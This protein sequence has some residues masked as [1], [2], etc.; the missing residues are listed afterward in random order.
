MNQVICIG[1]DSLDPKLLVK[2]EKDLP[3]FTKLRERSP[4]IHSKSVFPVDSIPAWVS[5]YTGLNPAKHGIIHSFDI[6]E[7][8][9][10]N[11]LGIDINAFKGRT[12][13]DRASKNGKK[14]CILLPFLATPPWDVNGLMV[15]ISTDEF[16]LPEEETWVIKKGIQ[17]YPP[18][19]KSKYQIP[20]F[21][22]GTKGR[23]PREKD[24]DK[25]ISVLKK[26]TIEESKLALRLS[27]NVEWD[28]F[29]MMFSW[30][31]IIQHF[32]WRFSDEDDP[33]YPGENPYRNVIKEFYQI[34]DNILGE[35]MDSYPEMTIIVFSDHGHAMRPVKTVNINEILRKKG[36]LISKSGKMNPV[37]YLLEQ[38]KRTSLDVIKKFELD[39]LM[40][41]VSKSKAFSSISKDIYMS[42]AS[43]DFERSKAYLSSF[44]GPKS[45][46]HAGIDINKQNLRDESY[47]EIRT[48]LIGELLKL[49]EPGTG[50]KLVDWACRREDL[51]QGS[52]LDFYPDVVF[53]L[54]E[55]YGAFW[56]IHTPLI[57]TAY[58]HKLASG[59]HHK[60][61]VFLIA[62]CKE[63]TK[64]EDISVI[65]IGPTILNLLGIKMEEEID[66][67]S[68]FEGICS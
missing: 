40:I 8:S 14:V 42:S 7:S 5:I 13:W 11:I 43:I 60:D 61:A 19:Y 18:E 26:S 17:T 10:K 22:K 31:D 56:G 6:F 59:G 4:V 46:S 47:E 44:A 57:G 30:L 27:N 41:R 20:D 1:I 62:N 35:F 55:G 34:Y 32:F 24:F 28:L 48:L 51:Y 25:Y 21:I 68:L 49:T 2:F 3:N 12:F 15:S 45:Y 50:K 16:P 66:G 9:W 67:K 65:D 58:E 38:A 29:F 53:E 52:N 39:Y 23:P 63:K 54:I 64:R 33:S 37:P 36:L